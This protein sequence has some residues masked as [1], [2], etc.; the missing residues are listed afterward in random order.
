VIANIDYTPSEAFVADQS[1]DSV[2]VSSIAAE[3]ATR[4][5]SS[6]YFGGEDGMTFTD[7]SIVVVPEPSS[8]LLG[9]L[10]LLGL[11]RRRRQA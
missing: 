11:L 6:I 3:W 2:D 8:A 1:F 10:G 4:E 7:F 5:N 9:G